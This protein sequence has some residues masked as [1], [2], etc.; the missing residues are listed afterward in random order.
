LGSRCWSTSGDPDYFI[1]YVDVTRVAEYRAEAAKLTGEASIAALFRYLS[2]SRLVSIAQIEGRV[3]A[4]GSEFV[5]RCDMRF[6]ARE[7]AILAQIEPVLG[8]LPGGG[9]AQ[10]R[11]I[12][13]PMPREAPV[14]STLR[15]AS[16]IPPRVGPYGEQH[17]RIEGLILSSSSLLA[18]ASPREGPLSL[19]RGIP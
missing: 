8:S 9:A 4:A 18:G 5:L 15:P 1:S 19:V 11:A 13:S 17:H 7:S 3:R 10:E 2:A 16:C 12:A 6:A 14:M